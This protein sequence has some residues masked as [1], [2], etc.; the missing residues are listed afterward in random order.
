MKNS[1]GALTNVSEAAGNNGDNHAASLVEEC[2]P[3]YEVI[4][5]STP[6]C[7]CRPRPFLSLDLPARPPPNKPAS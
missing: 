4:F 2:L 7:A 6:Q 1:A 5:P 3:R